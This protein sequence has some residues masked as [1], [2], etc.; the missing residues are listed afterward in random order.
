[1]IR[2]LPGLFKSQSPPP[3]AKSHDCIRS[4]GVDHVATKTKSDDTVVLI[5]HNVQVNYIYVDSWPCAGTVA[6][7]QLRLLDNVRGPTATIT[8]VE[9]RG[10]HSQYAHTYVSITSGVLMSSD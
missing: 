2:S 6:C 1:M 9:L 8:R 10:I 5:G 7:A 3:I 4:L